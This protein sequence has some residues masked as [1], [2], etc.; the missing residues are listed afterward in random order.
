MQWLK[1]KL[2]ATKGT[3]VAQEVSYLRHRVT[4]YGQLPDPSLLIASSSPL[5]P[6]FIW[7]H[8]FG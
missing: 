3:L 8:C 7:G 6:I 1:L 5:Y 2:G 4:R